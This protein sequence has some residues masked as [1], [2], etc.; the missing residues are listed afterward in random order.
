[1]HHILHFIDNIAEEFAANMFW[2]L[3][4]AP[5]KVTPVQRHTLSWEA[6]MERYHLYMYLGSYTHTG[7][8]APNIRCIFAPPAYVVHFVVL[9]GLRRPRR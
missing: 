6:A 9:V 1:M 5:R 7:Q 8:Y 3:N 4:N 2:A